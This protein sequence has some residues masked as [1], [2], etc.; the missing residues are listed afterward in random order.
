MEKNKKTILITGGAGFIGSHLCKK[1]LDEGHNVICVD[2]LQTTIDPK[3]IKDFFDNENFTFIKHDIIK[4]IKFNQKIDWIFNLACSGSYTVY[5][6]DPVHTVETNTVGVINMLELA[7]NNKARIMQFSTSEI[8]GDPLESPQKETYK[9]NVNTLGPR[10][11]YDEGKRCAETLFMDYY[12]EFDLDI[13]IIRIFNTYGP[14]MDMNDGRAVSNF[15]S[16]ALAGK[17]LAIY[18]DGT[19]T[20]SFQYIDDLVSGI[21]K[22]MVKDGFIGP[23]NLGNPGEVTMKDIAGIIIK[24][25]G[26]NSKIIFERGVSDD[27]KRRCPD[28][29]LANKELDWEPKISLSEG[30]DK[31]IEY[32]RGVARPEN[33]IV[34]FANTFYPDCGPAEDSLLSLAREMKDTEFH[35]I[36]TRF[37]KDRKNFESMGNVSIYRI[38]FGFKL[39]KYLLP[40]LGAIKAYYLDKKYDFKFAWSVMASYSGLAVLFTK[41]LIGNKINFLISLEPKETENVNII[42][43]TVFKPLLRAIL[44]NAESVHILDKDE[45]KYF[46]KIDSSINISHR[47]ADTGTFVKQLRSAHSDI[48]NKKQKKLSRPK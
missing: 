39:D 13:K 30:L 16:N 12:R 4:P 8:Y 31:T 35:V 25:I 1:Y 29:S 45:E 38:G 22:M 41:M 9:G 5:Q 36:T 17:D 28:I 26:S 10:A 27:P 44:K 24:K 42:K 19:Y 21:D 43:R 47:S 6:Y 37:K 15:V 48:L 7:R 32:F 40:V 2:N 33:K 11:C 23:V 20:R 34:V 18:G 46:K 14:N 3:N